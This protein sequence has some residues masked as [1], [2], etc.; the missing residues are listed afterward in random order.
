M[1]QDYE[2]AY[3]KPPK[4]SQFKPGQSGNPSGRPKRSN[5]ITALLK[6]ELEAKVT[7]TENGVKKTI[8]KREAMVRQVVN[9]GLK[10][11]ATDTLRLLQRLETLLPREVE[12]ETAE[13]DSFEVTFV[14]AYE[15]KPFNPTDEEIAHLAKRREAKATQKKESK[16]QNDEELNFLND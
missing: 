9:G 12:P 5:T 6:E 7:V 1:S 14:R 2:V 8:T 15:G 11:K 16:A 3:G 13:P 10:G 4:H